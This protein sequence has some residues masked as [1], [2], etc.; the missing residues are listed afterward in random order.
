MIVKNPIGL[1]GDTLGTFPVLQQLNKDHEH[2]SVVINEDARDLYSLVPEIRICECNKAD[3][4]LNLSGAFTTAHMHGIYMVQAHYPFMGY[5]IPEKPIKADLRIIDITTK[6][7]KFYDYVI[8]PF[9]RSAPNEQ[10]WSMDKWV[11]LIESMPEFSFAILGNS[12][13]DDW[14]APV[15]E[16]ATLFFDRSMND[17]GYT[18]QRAKYGCIS[19][20][21]GISH[22]CYHLGVKNYLLT[23]QTG[24]TWGENPDCIAI[25]DHIPTLEPKTV[26]DLLSQER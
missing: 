12:K 15:P 7:T 19:I 23:N 14:A 18:L 4:E 5:S 25:R 16:N 10:K 9:G 1:I 13:Y 11:Q 21:T 2:F 8:A 26:Y 20:V 22:F 24:M 6:D 3:K 17:V